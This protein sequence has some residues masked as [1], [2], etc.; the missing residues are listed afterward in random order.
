M[1]GIFAFITSSKKHHFSSPLLAEY[2]NSPFLA[3]RP[4]LLQDL[5]HQHP[6]LHFIKPSRL[7]LAQVDPTLTAR[8]PDHQNALH[9]DHPY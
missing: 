6:L 7:E 8:G 5:L 2:L 4:Q 9:L 1:C 3:K